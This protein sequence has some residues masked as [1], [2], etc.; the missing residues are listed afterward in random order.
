MIAVGAALGLRFK[1][2]VLVP[3]IATTSIGGLA[4]GIGDSVWSNLLAT[5]SVITALQIGYVAGT[6]VNFGASTKADKR[7]SD[8]I[9][10]TNAVT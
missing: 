8:A 7:Q 2:F 9:R 5:L 3:A 4:V 1:A 6:I 10:R